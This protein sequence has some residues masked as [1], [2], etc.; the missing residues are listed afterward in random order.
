[1]FVNCNFSPD[2]VS[3]ILFEAACKNLGLKRADFELTG[4]KPLDYNDEEVSDEPESYQVSLRPK[5]LFAESVFNQEEQSCSTAI[6]H[7]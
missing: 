2:E 1:M 3:A 6:N 4:L 5:P 7:P